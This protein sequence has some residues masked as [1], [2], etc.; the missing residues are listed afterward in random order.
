MASS[1]LDR[2][3]MLDAAPVSIAFGGIAIDRPSQVGIDG[4]LNIVDEG[5]LHKVSG[6]Q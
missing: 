4:P 3:E 6:R 1:F 5:W 2:I